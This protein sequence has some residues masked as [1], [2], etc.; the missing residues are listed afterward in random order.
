MPKTAKKEAWELTNNSLYYII[1]EWILSAFN[2]AKKFVALRKDENSAL[3]NVRILLGMSLNL[4]KGN[5]SNVF[6]VER[7]YGLLVGD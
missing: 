7:K 5:G 6:I 3:R 2:V 1:K 4:K